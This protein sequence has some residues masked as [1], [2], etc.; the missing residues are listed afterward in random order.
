MALV[1]DRV[2]VELEAKLDRYNANIVRAQGVFDRRLGMMERNARRVETAIGNNFSGMAN[3]VNVAL[4]GIGVG[5]GTAELIKYADAWTNLT[6]RLQAAGIETDRIAAKKEEL[7]AIAQRTRQPITELG[8]LYSRLEIA[9]REL[10]TSEAD[11]TRVTETMAKAMSLGGASTQEAAAAMLQFSQAIGAGVL[12]GDELRSIRE[13]APLV[14][15]A[16]AKEFNTTVGG[17]KKLGEEGKLTSD[18]I[19]RA[20]LR[21]SSETDK[22]FAK[23]PVTIGQSFTVLQNA[24]TRYVGQADTANGVSA[25]LSG[26]MIG[27]ANNIDTVAKSALLAGASILA[28]TGPRAVAGIATMAA[29]MAAAA[30]PIGIV[31]GLIGAAAAALVLFGDRITP[32]QGQLGT[33]RDYAVAAF[34]QLRG[35]VESASAVVQASFQTIL[36]TMTSA[37]SGVGVTWE[38]VGNT[39]RAVI[40]A[41]LGSMIAVQ[42]I[43][44]DVLPKLPAAVGEAI[45]DSVNQLIRGV[46]AQINAAIE[47]LRKF[48]AALSGV[49]A[50]AAA[51]SA[52]MANLGTVNLPQVENNFRGAGKLAGDAFGATMQAA[53]QDHIATVGAAVQAQLDQI[54]AR[55]A[56][57]AAARFNALGATDFMGAPQ[58]PAGVNRVKPATSGKTNPYDNAIRKIQEA[59]RVQKLEFEMI[60]KTNLERDKELA[61]LE[62]EAAA[63]KAKIP[64]NEKMIAQIDRETTA[65]ANWKEQVRLA[66]ERQRD[67]Q[68]LTRE[69]GSIAIDGIQGL[70]DGTKSWNDILKDT[71]RTLSQM[72]LKAALL[73]EGPL[74][75]FFGTSPATRGGVG[76]IFGS[77]LSAFGGFRAGGGPVQAGKSYVVGEKGPELVRFGKNGT[78]VP[79][80][81]LRGNAVQ[82]GGNVVF[83]NDFRDASAPAIAAILVRL[84]RLEASLPTM[85]PQMAREARRTNPWG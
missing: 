54:A 62:L 50:V 70:I 71:L 64:L 68:E 55:A 51:V 49:S 3:R 9:A 75:S 82:S 39:I 81:A 65:Y 57:I 77:I 53:A 61:T 4:A 35:G 37:L 85:V 26:A 17:L 44:T 23:L 58:R 22:A 24:I 59:T 8:Q 31:V 69:L 28:M 46:E 42:K 7:F 29:S 41:L 21:V 20:M 34:E 6:A 32:V 84:G 48:A 15:Q 16:I 2:V 1:A 83:N 80:S 12:Q 14:A 43:A 19:I 38:Q 56:Q 11:I 45:V 76:G 18:R 63:R 33:L 60:G 27:L 10:G 13:N 74:A 5:L 66:T 30:G 73:G 67:L 79:N 52:A 72:A 36:A 25:A 47:G 40:N 78:V